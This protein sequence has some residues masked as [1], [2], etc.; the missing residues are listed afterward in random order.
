MKNDI[1]HDDRSIT[2]GTHKVQSLG[3]AVRARSCLGRLDLARVDL[4]SDGPG[5]AIGQC[6]DKDG[7]DNHP[8][9][10]AVIGVDAIRCVE[11]ADE[12][13][14]GGHDEAASDNGTTASPCISVEE[15]GDGDKE[16]EDCGNAGGEER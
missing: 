7:N 2:E 12:E 15:C 10:S 9:G 1:C 14:A 4:G 3:H 13:H 5:H 8:S 11:G 6:E 16:H